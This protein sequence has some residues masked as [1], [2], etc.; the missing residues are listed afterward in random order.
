MHKLRFGLAILAVVGVVGGALA[1]SSGHASINSLKW[2][3]RRVERHPGLVR[4]SYPRFASTW[5]GCTK[6]HV[7]PK[8]GCRPRRWD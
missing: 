1:D 8:N 5:N 7:G 2:Q 3:M 4:N 6:N